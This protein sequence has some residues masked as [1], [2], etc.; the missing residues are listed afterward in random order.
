MKTVSYRTLLLASSWALCA[1]VAIGRFAGDMARP[2]YTR[3]IESSV[4]VEE[5]RVFKRADESEMV[6][7]GS[8]RL[9]RVSVT[10]F[11][12]RKFVYY[13]NDLFP[14]PLFGEKCESGVPLH[15]KRKVFERKYGGE[16]TVRTR[17]AF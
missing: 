14:S 9:T 15:L 12:P 2:N 11:G 16:L 6:I 7:E 8:D 1:G 5:G 3:W 13:N 4:P 10:I 17:C